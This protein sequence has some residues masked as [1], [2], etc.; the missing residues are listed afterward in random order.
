[1]WC[2]KKYANKCDRTHC[3]MLKEGGQM[4][5]WISA[6]D[7]MPGHRQKVLCYCW[8]GIY[9]VFVWDEKLDAWEKSV[10]ETFYSKKCFVRYWM[11]LPPK[12]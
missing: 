9:D 12:P 8:G 2:E 4:S 3:Y 6:K 11:P 7:K 10:G 5:E 1:M